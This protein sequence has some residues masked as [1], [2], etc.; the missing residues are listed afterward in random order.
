MHSKAR[1]GLLGRKATKN[2]AVVNMS[3]NG[4]VGSPSCPQPIRCFKK[5]NRCILMKHFAKYINLGLF[6]YPPRRPP[7]P[8]EGKSKMFQSSL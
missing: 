6:A 5:R 1:P 3:V 7:P 2:L 4:G 8:R